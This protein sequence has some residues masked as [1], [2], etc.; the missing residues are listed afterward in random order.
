MTKV[1]RIGPLLMVTL[2]LSACSTFAPKDDDLGKRTFGTRSNDGRSAKLIM[3]NLKAAIPDV[4][5]MN[6]AVTVF[7]GVALLTG[8][9]NTEQAKAHAG[10]IAEQIRH[11]AKVHNELEVAGPTAGLVRTN[12]ALLK[13]KLKLK[14]STNAAV[15]AGRT[16]VVVENGVV[17][18]MGLLTRDEAKAAVEL[19]R[20]VFGV[21]KIVQAFEY[22]N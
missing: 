19:T 10:R 18:L 11:V 12:D 5:T 13:T 6:V 2:L 22:L 14:M 16:K 8:Q 7:N 1:H 3:N 21:Q 20:E 9:T 15:D 4:K 17:Y